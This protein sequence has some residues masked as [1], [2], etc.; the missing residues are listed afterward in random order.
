MDVIYLTPQNLKKINGNV[1]PMEAQY[2]EK[3]NN[4]PY[5]SRHAC[6]SPKLRA[7][8]KL[9]NTLK[10]NRMTDGQCLNKRKTISSPFLAYPDPLFENFCEN[11]L[12][13][14]Y[15]DGI[16]GGGGC[17]VSGFYISHASNIFLS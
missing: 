1:E 14:C 5:F 7:L 16:L 15:Q 2:S 12:Q 11:K 3:R 17:V 6:I 13:F 8:F 10:I 4:S 9:Q